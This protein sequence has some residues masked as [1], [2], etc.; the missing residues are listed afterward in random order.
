MN[1]LQCPVFRGGEKI[2]IRWYGELR[3]AVATGLP[4]DSRHWP[5]GNIA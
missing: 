4:R 2:G 5:T 1:K 3:D